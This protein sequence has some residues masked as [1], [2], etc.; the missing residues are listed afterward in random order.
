MAKRII[1]PIHVKW[2]IIWLFYFQLNL[3]IRLLAQYYI[4]LNVLLLRHKYYIS[5]LIFLWSALLL[6]VSLKFTPWKGSGLFVLVDNKACSCN[7]NIELLDSLCE[8]FSPFKDFFDKQHTFLGYYKWYLDRDSRILS[9]ILVVLRV[10][11]CHTNIIII[12]QKY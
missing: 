11:L 6:R 1:I 9:F 2:Y 4:F 8:R 12:P 7:F 3:V 10:Y 5:S